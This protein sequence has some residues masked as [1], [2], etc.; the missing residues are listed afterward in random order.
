MVADTIDGK[1]DHFDNSYRIEL[2]APDQFNA[3]LLPRDYL[4]VE[5]RIAKFEFP[6]CYVGA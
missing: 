2:A 5:K 3:R 6:A 4:F 1:P